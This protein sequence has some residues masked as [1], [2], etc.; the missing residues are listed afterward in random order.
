MLQ[1]FEFCPCVLCVYDP[2]E[3]ACDKNNHNCSD[4]IDIDNDC[5][6]CPTKKGCSGREVSLL[7]TWEEALCDK[8]AAKQ[9]GMDKKAFRKW[10]I[11][12]GGMP[13]NDDFCPACR[14]EKDAYYR[15]LACW[16]SRQEERKRFGNE[17]VKPTES[18]WYY[19]GTYRGGLCTP[20]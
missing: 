1:I 11:D 12:Q 13:P 5:N 20:K 15:E 4:W 17:Q 16:G 19:Q 10:R 9:C 6:R 2:P 8:H 18:I 3:G 14:A 7:K